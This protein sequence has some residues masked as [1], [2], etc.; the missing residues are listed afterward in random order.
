MRDLMAR[1]FGWVR[2]LSGAGEPPGPAPAAP[3]PAPAG[4]DVP[5]LIAPYHLWV[6]PHGF[7]VRPRRN[8]TE[9]V[10]CQRAASGV[11]RHPCTECRDIKRTWIRVLDAG[12]RP[13]AEAVIVAMGRHQRAAHA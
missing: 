10:V 8:M 11:R 13:Q 6:T 7:D 2:T 5:E 1:W 9:G 12:D 4:P 3:Q